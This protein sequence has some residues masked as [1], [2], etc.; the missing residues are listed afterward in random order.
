MNLKASDVTEERAPFEM[1]CVSM[2]VMTF[3]IVAC[4]TAYGFN[5]SVDS[6]APLAFGAGRPLELHLVLYRQLLLIAALAV[7]LMAA[8]FNARPLL[9]FVC[10][11]P[12]MAA[13][14][15]RIL[16]TMAWSV[17]G[18]L[19]YDCLSHWA[20]SQ[21]QQALVTL[22]A[23]AGLGVN[24]TLNLVLANPA[25]PFSAPIAALIAQNTLAPV[26]LA[27]GL[28]HA[29]R[30]PLVPLGSVL[31]G[32]PAQLGTSL[33][34]MC[35]SCAELWAWQAQVFEA[36]ALGAGDAASYS[37]LSSTYAFLMRV[38]I[39][40]CSGLTALV[41]E[42]IGAG[43]PGRARELLAMGCLYG[44]VA[45]VV[46]ALP[47][48]L[49]RREYAHLIS[50]G[51]A[52]VQNTLV[53][54]LPTILAMQLC[55]GLFNVMKAWLVVRQHQVFGAVQSLVVYYTVGVPLGWWLAFR[56]GWGLV[57]LWC[58]MGAAVVLG[59]AASAT[60]VAADV[61]ALCAEGE[62]CGSDAARDA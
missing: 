10:V 2:A 17:P 60:K 56:Q 54:V 21:Q 7:L 43:L 49:A 59:L 23:A 28:F 37:L 4:A 50:G 42:A 52:V 53:A 55:D 14:T 34:Q 12:A 51:I 62:G 22:C 3:N 45:V 30:P 24:L 48:L 32:L 46:Y 31:K 5:G 57:G 36:R 8:L 25:A 1:D 58:G 19:V 33:A 61:Q 47:L 6:Y 18:Y 38:P 16:G 13:H 40:A 15:G 27:T 11:P 44:T 39:G 20:Q 9:L 35:W 41:G 29:R 26:F